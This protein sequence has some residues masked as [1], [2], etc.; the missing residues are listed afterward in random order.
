MTTTTRKSGMDLRGLGMFKSYELKRGTEV[1]ARS[2]SCGELIAK[3]LDGASIPE[4]T[5]TEG[6]K[7][8]CRIYDAMVTMVK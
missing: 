8:V 1:I 5:I 3:A 7:V 4:M 2:D 6:G